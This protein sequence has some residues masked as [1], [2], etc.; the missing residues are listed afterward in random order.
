LEGGHLKSFPPQLPVP[1]NELIT[2]IFPG[3]VISV[4]GGKL[5]A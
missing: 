4:A 1:D 3:E 5:V 2:I